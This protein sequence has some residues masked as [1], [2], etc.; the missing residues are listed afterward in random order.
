MAADERRLSGNRLRLDGLDKLVFGTSRVGDQCVR[1]ATRGNALD[2]VWNGSRPERTTTTKSTFSAPRPRSVVASLIAPRSIANF[3][4]V[5]SRP[6]PTI[7][8][9]TPRVWRAIPTEPPMRP[10][11]T[12]ATESHL[13][14]NGRI[15]VRFSLRVDGSHSTRLKS[16]ELGK[17]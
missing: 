6:I 2:Q 14:G 12:I 16:V 1:R 8:L 13:D 4:R 5:G 7:R 3:S 9:A 11:P 15:P 17:S 10:T